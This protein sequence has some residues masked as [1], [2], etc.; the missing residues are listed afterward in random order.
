MVNLKIMT[1]KIE[2]QTFWQQVE[3]NKRTMKEDTTKEF[4][5][6]DLYRR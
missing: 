3:I 5:N 6:F 2:T 1:R 4:L